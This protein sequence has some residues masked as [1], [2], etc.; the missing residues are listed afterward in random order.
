MSSVD[1][2]ILINVLVTDDPV[3]EPVEGSGQTSKSPM[4]Q[5]VLCQLAI[6]VNIASGNCKTTLGS[7]SPNYFHTATVPASATASS[8]YEYGNITLSGSNPWVIIWSWAHS[9]F[10]HGILGAC[11]TILARF[12]QM[13]FMV[14]LALNGDLKLQGRKS[15]FV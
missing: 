7:W 3:G 10:L 8:E 5:T 9:A 1:E 12:R 11:L 13:G 15:V 4:G 14:D 2:V 6:K